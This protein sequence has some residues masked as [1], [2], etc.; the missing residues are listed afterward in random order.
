M[1]RQSIVLSS[2]DIIA[3]IMDFAI[4]AAWKIRWQESKEIYS[5]LVKSQARAFHTVKES[6]S[7]NVWILKTSVNGIYL[8]YSFTVK[9]IWSFTLDW[10]TVHCEKIQVIRCRW[11]S[12]EERDCLTYAIWMF[13]KFSWTDNWNDREWNGK[14]KLFNRHTSSSTSNHNS[15]FLSLT[16][17]SQDLQA[18]VMWAWNETVEVVLHI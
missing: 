16:E 12:N 17:S 10:I 18:H 14:R 5:K 3:I 11:F 13:L 6:W 15:P 4:W 8:L 2:D 9:L 7:W 1:K